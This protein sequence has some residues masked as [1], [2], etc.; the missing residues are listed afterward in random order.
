MA[1]AG[2]QSQGGGG[3]GA[4]DNH[5]GFLWI[6][7]AVFILGCAIWYLFRAE[8]ISGIF[9]FKRAEI[10]L[11]SLFTNQ[12]DSVHA[13]ILQAD[14]NVVTIGQVGIVASAV[15]TY[16]R[17][18]GALLLLGLAVLVYV[19]DIRSK[20]KSTYSMEKLVQTERVNWPQITPVVSLN[21]VEEDID[22]GKW[23]MALTPLQFVKKHKL[24]TLHQV[25]SKLKYKSHSLPQTMKLIENKANTVFAS[26][27]GKPWMGIDNLAIH[28]KALF[29]IFAA[30][31][32]YDIDDAKQLLQQIASSAMTGQLDFSGV[33]DLL[34]QYRDNGIV[35]KITQGHAYE[36]TVMA[37]MLHAARDAGVL[38]SAEFLWLKPVDRMLWYMLNNVGRCTAFCEVAGPFAHWLAERAMGKQLRAPMIAEATCGLALALETIIY[39]DNEHPET[40]KALAPP[41]VQED[42]N[43][44][45][46][47]ATEGEG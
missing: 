44:V 13:W 2:Q 5:M 20:F 39:I 26:Q 34:S 1:G 8:I 24:I 23:A 9:Y 37:S 43:V 47:P 30:R 19:S 33:D 21:L 38:A 6:L 3:G 16:F 11:I 28:T 10:W 7:F 42:E 45:I 14:P 40:P 25:E 35:M 22:S 31:I 36:L 46:A 12:L 32:S 17:I 4:K 27:L 18:P 41:L 15:G 29:A